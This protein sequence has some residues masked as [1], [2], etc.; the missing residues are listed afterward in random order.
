VFATWLIAWLLGVAVLAGLIAGSWSISTYRQLNQD[1]APQPILVSKNAPI[2]DVRSAQEYA[3]AHIP[4]SI[5]LYE[6]EVERI[7]QAYPDKALR[8]ALLQRPVLWQEQ[9]ALRTACQIRLYARE[10]LSARSTCL[11]RFGQLR[12]N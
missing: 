3:I 2:L 4:G 1:G 7:T 10:A 11:A 12:A 8:C 5:N 6:R 9:A